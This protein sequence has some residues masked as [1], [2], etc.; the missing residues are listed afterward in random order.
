M[1][2]WMSMEEA[3]VWVAIAVF[4]FAAWSLWSWRK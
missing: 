4:T 1:I 2:Q 3:E